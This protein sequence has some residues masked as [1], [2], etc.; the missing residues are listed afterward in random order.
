MKTAN[1]KDRSSVK[2]AVQLTVHCTFKIYKT[3]QDQLRL[4]LTGLAT[5]EG[6]EYFY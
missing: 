6:K 4:V 1:G 2:T 5:L 3:M